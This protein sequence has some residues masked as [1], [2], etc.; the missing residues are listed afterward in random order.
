M[1]TYQDNH[2]TAADLTAQARA[3]ADVAGLGFRLGRFLPSVDNYS[4]TYD[5][6]VNDIGLT[7]LAEYRAFDT[8]ANYGAGS[9][10]SGTR[11][12]ALPPVSRKYR[13]KEQEQL[14]L[15]IGG[16]SL[17][18]DKQDEYA[19]KG[20]LAI[21]ARVALAQA[22]A[23]EFAK[24]DLKEN[25]L[26]VTIDYGRD[27]AHDV[28]SAALFSDIEADLVDP[29]ESWASAYRAKNGVNP[30]TTLLSQRIITAASKN[31]SVIR[32]TVGRFA[33]LP[34]R[35]GYPDVIAF[36]AAYGLTGVEIFDAV[37]DGTR[38][39]SENK[40]FLLPGDSNTILDGGPL[41]TTEWGITAESIQPVYGIG[42]AERPGIFSAAFD[43]ND[44][45]G[46][47]VLSTAVVV[48]ALRNADATFVAEVLTA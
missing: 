44:P 12:G 7:D 33:D 21:A 39:L 31:K 8:E 26:N 29:L 27:P 11:S 10:T 37:L 22:Q 28:V 42:D 36:F 1:P 35:V 25:K 14:T 4:L 48:P 3:A 30:G 17:I 16:A 13:V 32:Y 34:T 47:D 41:G 20:G 5:F 15:F 40:I 6:N 18:G 45:Q 46:T 43:D 23:I 24:V 19:R 2:R 9:S 38:L